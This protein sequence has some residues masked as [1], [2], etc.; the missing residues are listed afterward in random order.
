MIAVASPKGRRCIF[1]G[2]PADSK[3]DVIPKW[4]RP[5]I[6][7]QPEKAKAN[8]R[9]LM[10]RRY[11]GKK[12]P[13]QTL[14]TLVLAARRVVCQRCNNGWMSQLQEAAKMVIGPLL[15][16]QRVVLMPDAQAQIAGWLTMTSMVLE[17]YA[18][19]ASG[20]YY[21][22]PERERL[23]LAWE[24]PAVTTV[25]LARRDSSHLAAFSQAFQ[26][27]FIDTEAP[28]LAKVPAFVHTFPLG[29][30]TF[31]LLVYRRAPE[32]SSPAGAAGVIEPPWK[33]LAIAFGVPT[34]PLSWPPPHSLDDISLLA[35]AGRWGPE[36]R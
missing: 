29:T 21:I 3:E 33:D 28:D 14:M 31:Q 27:E 5:L 12:A 18:Q 9:F 24:I 10:Q 15:A 19:P 22:Q 6:E 17:A 8:A 16:D 26:F 36:Q 25:W 7:I 34:D 13:D 11:A 20:C 23:R 4:I 30:A 2:S 1:C 35:F 32:R